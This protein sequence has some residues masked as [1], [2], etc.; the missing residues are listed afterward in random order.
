MLDPNGGT[1]VSRAARLLFGKP[2]A[3]PINS[4]DNGDIYS[5]NLAKAMLTLGNG[6]PNEALRFAQEAYDNAQEAFG[7]SSPSLIPCQIIIAQALS[8][9]NQHEK[10]INTYNE[11]LALCAD[12]HEHAASKIIVGNII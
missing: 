6:K 4:A 8:R 10:A 7:K 5:A 9:S 11:A 12:S 2:Q 3:T 1:T